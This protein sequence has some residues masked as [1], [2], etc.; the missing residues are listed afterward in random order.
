MSDF[1]PTRPAGRIG[2][3]RDDAVI[4]V[5]NAVLRL[6]SPWLQAMVKGSVRY[7]MQAAA[8]D[9]VTPGPR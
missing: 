6:G 1:R 8:R 9:S 3:A 2:R 5:A 7:G 4:G